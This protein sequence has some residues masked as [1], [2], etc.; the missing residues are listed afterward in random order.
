MTTAAIGHAGV[1][2]HV[3]LGAV[4][5]IHGHELR[6]AIGSHGKE[7]GLADA[8][9]GSQRPGA[10]AHR[11]LGLGVKLLSFE[12]LDL[13]ERVD[14]V[15]GSGHAFEHSV[16]LVRII[17]SSGRFGNVCFAEFG[18]KAHLAKAEV[19]ERLRI[20]PSNT[21]TMKIAIDHEANLSVDLHDL[22]LGVKDHHAA[23]AAI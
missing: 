21:R 9:V 17:K 12:Q 15:S 7:L 14:K 20:S 22:G 3:H 11:Q 13:I 8:H 10:L 16:E 19:V 4:D 6:I 2:P 23:V 5:A 1:S 18:Q